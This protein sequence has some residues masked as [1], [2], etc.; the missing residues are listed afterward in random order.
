MLFRS[1]G[2]FYFYGYHNRTIS[3]DINSIKEGTS[4]AAT[5]TAVKTALALNKQVSAYEIHVETNKGLVT[6]TG[7]VPTDGDKK[8]VEGQTSS[9]PL[10]LLDRS[11]Y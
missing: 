5:T 8:T 10:E 7:L 3:A 9:P 6:L 4:E 2:L 11:P 1:A